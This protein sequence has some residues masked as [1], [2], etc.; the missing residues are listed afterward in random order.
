MRRAPNKSLAHLDALVAQVLDL[1]DQ[2]LPRVHV[3]DVV[4]AAD[5]DAVDHDVGHG[6]AARRA[7]E[8]LLQLGAERV[9]VQLDDE[10]RRLDEVLFQQEA[11][12]P[13]GEGAVG[14]GE[15]DY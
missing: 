1:G 6:R 11:L 2:L 15:D 14:L 13:L 8:Q 3:G 5:A 7:A 4:G 10:G 9:R 12:G